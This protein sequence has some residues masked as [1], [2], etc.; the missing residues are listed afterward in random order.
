M[1]DSVQVQVSNYCT[2]LPNK[3]AQAVTI[4]IIAVAVGAMY[5]VWSEHYDE[6]DLLGTQVKDRLGKAGKLLFAGAA[7]SLSGVL[8]Y[9]ILH[10]IIHYFKQRVVRNRLNLLSQSTRSVYQFLSTALLTMTWIAVSC[11]LVDRAITDNELSKYITIDTIVSLAVGLAVRPL[12]GNVIDGF[13]IVISQRVS[14]DNRILIPGT[15]KM[16]TVTSLG[17]LGLEVEL[18]IEVESSKPNTDNERITQCIYVPFSILQNG[19]ITRE[20]RP[21]AKLAH[22]APL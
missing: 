22:T 21:P 13:V 6:L 1:P 20:K 11:V 2:R 8:L 10:K 5:W 18:E 4:A 14:L 15:D 7:L 19:T 17:L 16:G 3:S 9:S 12:F